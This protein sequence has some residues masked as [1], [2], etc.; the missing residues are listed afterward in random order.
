MV[1]RLAF[2]TVVIGLL[3][4]IALRV[5]GQPAWS[6]TILSW[7]CGV[8]IGLPVVNL[9]GVL[10]DEVR[11]RDWTFAGVALAVLMLLA[12]ALQAAWRRP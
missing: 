4:G 3:S 12:Y 9:T 6:A 5:L 8:L 11:R 1:N 7:T 10:A 2:Q